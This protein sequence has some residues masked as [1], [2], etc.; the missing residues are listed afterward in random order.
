MES[1][2]NICTMIF[3]QVMVWHCKLSYKLRA[4]TVRQHASF[5]N[6]AYGTQ[7]PEQKMDIYL[8]VNKGEVNVILLI[9][10]GNW[11]MGD[12]ADYT[13]LCTHVREKGLCC[14]TINYR[15]LK[16]LVASA[17]QPVNYSDMLDDIG[18]AIAG[19]KIKL[20]AE[21]YA[22]RKIALFGSSA[23]GH[24]AL[25][26][27]YSRY[28]QSAIPI[29]FLT[30]EC[31]P[32]DFTDRTGFNKHSQAEVLWQLSLLAGQA[33]SDHEV[34]NK[35]LVLQDMS[36]FYHMKAGVPP[37]LMCHGVRDELVPFS[38]A[39]NLKKVLGLAGVR[40][41]L[42]EYLHSGH[43]QVHSADKAI[44]DAYYAKFQE[45]IDTYFS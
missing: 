12:K 44:K 4:S 21:G 42:F 9:H 30:A 34:L 37:T 25:L 19:L 28:S 20:T 29:A 39:T 43:G 24:L 2:R 40:N 27:A 26:Y 1:I 14:V 23:G 31:A 5:A 17:R 13:D 33:I 36:P 41:D 8:P 45:Y 10:G 35:V 15:M 6:Y 18:S 16:P 38:Q 7:S 22:P 3:M 11:I 32:T